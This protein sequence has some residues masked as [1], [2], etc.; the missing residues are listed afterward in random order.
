MSTSV[1]PESGPYRALRDRLP[2]PEILVLHGIAGCVFLLSFGL[3]LAAQAVP[4]HWLPGQYARLLGVLWAL[5]VSVLMTH[6][7]ARQH[8]RDIDIYS[9]LGCL[10][11]A[12]WAALCL[13][14]IAVPCA[15]WHLQEHHS[16]WFDQRLL[17][18]MV[19]SFALC[20]WSALL[21]RRAVHVWYLLHP[22]YWEAAD[23]ARPYEHAELGAYWAI[24]ECGVLIARL[25]IW[26]LLGSLG[27]GLVVLLRSVEPSHAQDVPAIWAVLAFLAFLTLGPVL[28]GQAVQLRW[29]TQWTVDRVRATPGVTSTWSRF[30]L[31]ALLLAFACAGLL[32]GALVPAHRGLL[33]L[34]AQVRL[35]VVTMHLAPHATPV[36]TAG[37]AGQLAPSGFGG[38]T[39]GS[40]PGGASGWHLSL[41]HLPATILLVAA[42]LVLARLF[43][44]ARRQHGTGV[45]R[46]LVLAA[47][48]LEVRA[49]LAWLV[50]C[51]RRRERGPEA[52]A[53][54]D[55]GT[56]VSPRRTTGRE[57]RLDE[58]ASR[59]VILTVYG[60]VLALAATRGYQRRPGQT[61]LEHARELGAALP[62]TREA[63][64]G[65]SEL[66]IAARYGARGPS[67]A[68]AQ[69]SEALWRI[70]RRA[71]RRS[72]GLPR[73]TPE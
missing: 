11:T 8:A 49:Y 59:Q 9:Y 55:T 44:R 4:A 57:P 63:V 71:M 28:I 56:M 12:R 32:T 29:R 39:A 23:E 72:H 31:T 41:P 33:W 69:R 26:W 58:L 51:C 54:R 16:T 61:P 68:E 2:E 6:R 66:F 37:D 13:A 34:C 30:G 21:A 20:W 27:L 22:Q 10:R 3:L 24:R 14:L 7:Y 70:F 53:M 15:Q 19:L 25:W 18:P 38:V 62:G 42:L 73:R 40:S 35:P 64:R 36:N 46:W 65:L 47:L 67:A 48:A 43:V 5:P 45:S 60:W 17:W 1:V 50:Q 52:G